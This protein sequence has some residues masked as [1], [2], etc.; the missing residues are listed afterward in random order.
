[1]VPNEDPR[2][3]LV[4]HAFQAYDQVRR[5]RTQRV[6][7]TSRE[8]GQLVAM[9]AEGGGGGGDVGRMGRVLGYR[10]HWVWNRGMREQNREAVRLF[11]EGL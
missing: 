6:V 11:R 5:V 10:L 1:M 4:P 7:T 9:R 3:S 8:A 2:P